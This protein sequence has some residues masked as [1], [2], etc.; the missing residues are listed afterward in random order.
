MKPEITKEY[1]DQLRQALEANDE[2]LAFKMFE[3]FHPVDIAEVYQELDL[4]EARM[5]YMLLDDE[6]AADVLAELDEEERIKLL[7]TLPP[8]VIARKFIYHMDSDDAADVLSELPE[9]TKEA[10]LLHLKDIEQ[11]GDIVDLLSF[12]EDSAGGLMAKELIKVNE[13]WSVQTSLKEMRRQAEN[14]D[15]VYYVYVVDDDNVLKGVL[16]LKKLLLAKWNARVKNLED[17]D[18]ISV[19]T[20]T[21]ADEVASIMK[22]YDLVV[23]PVTDSIGR[24]VGRITIDDIVD[25]IKEEAD[26]DY[27]MASGLSED[28]EITDS[29]WILTRARLPWLLIALF[30]GLLVNLII[31]NYEDEIK[32]NPEMAFFMPLIAAMAGNMGIQ[33]SAIV[34]QGIANNTLGFEGLFRKLLK[35]FF[36]GTMNGIVLSAILVAFSLIT[37]HSLSLTITVSLSLFVVI[38]FSAVFGTMIPLLLHRFKVDPALATGPFITTMNDIMGLTIYFSMGRILFD[39]V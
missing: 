27:Q 33:S 36:V 14:V 30:G 4:E 26:K 21:P 15:E 6:T 34:V 11:A 31:S 29:A 18:I 16:S 12:D 8:E 32:I 25:V 10:I 2:V 7:K 20:D 5:L 1:L 22:K 9:E 39:L 28:V 19:R 24:L 23:V 38:V 17:T 3:D 13:N 35:E 37:A